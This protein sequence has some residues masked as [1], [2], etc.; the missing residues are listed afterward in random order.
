ML[1]KRIDVYCQTREVSRFRAPDG[2]RGP[3]QDV[4]RLRYTPVFVSLRSEDLKREPGVAC[5]RCNLRG[6]LTQEH[7]PPSRDFSPRTCLHPT[8]PRPHTPP[9]LIA[10]GARLHG[11]EELEECSLHAV[12]CDGG[13]G[14][15][16]EGAVLVH[17]PTAGGRAGGRA[18]TDHGELSLFRQLLLWLGRDRLIE[19]TIRSGQGEGTLSSSL[20]VQNNA[21]DRGGLWLGMDE[22]CVVRRDRG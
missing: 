1:R 11:E 8:T 7:P 20:L 9:G 17:L 13:H 15:V 10:G 12:F 4:S 18:V 3:H 5:L 16:R 19:Y 21:T 2:R 6:G 14:R 22:P